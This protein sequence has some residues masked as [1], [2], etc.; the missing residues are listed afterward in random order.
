M[1][2]ILIFT[3][4]REE[5]I[6]VVKQVLWTLRDNDLHL[7]PEKCKFHKDKPNHLGYTISKDYVVIEDSKVKAIEDWPI[8]HTVYDICSFLGLKNFYQRFIDKFSL[9]S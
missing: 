7:K 6:L 9:I 2:N 1:N 4:T 8:P 5:H 3:K